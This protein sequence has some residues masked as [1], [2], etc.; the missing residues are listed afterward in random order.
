MSRREESTPPSLIIGLDGWGNAGEASTMSVSYLIEKLKAKEV[1][2]IGSDE[3]YNY[4]ISRPLVSIEGGLVRR[5]D[6]LRN[7]LYE[8]KGDRIVI[9]LKGVEPHLN[10]SK[11]VDKIFEYCVKYEVKE[12]YTLGGYLVDL[13]YGRVSA[14]SGST[15]NPE[16]IEEL[17][18]CGVE[19]ANYE[20]ATSVY[21]EILW[22]SR[23][24]G[25]DT[26]SLWVA[27]PVYMGNRNPAA[28]LH[29]LKT[30]ICLSNLKVDLSEMIRAVRRFK[31]ELVKEAEENP[32]LRGLTESLD[33]DDR[34]WSMPPYTV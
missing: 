15:N 23:K 1:G 5:Y 14:V 3:F 32:K 20:G 29:L 27:T 21:S 17:K 7:I 25:I 16:K 9:I 11:Y 33:L 24:Y 12:I 10:W 19:L 13:T 2:E 4:Q 30:L 28:A 22:R 26:V 8:W 34:D 18:R 6:K 31:A